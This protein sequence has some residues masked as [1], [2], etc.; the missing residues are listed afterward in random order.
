MTDLNV[1]LD[2]GE[3][4]AVTVR[5]VDQ[6]GYLTWARPTLGVEAIGDDYIAFSTYGATRA[7]IRTGVLDRTDDTTMLDLITRITEVET[8]TETEDPTPP[9]A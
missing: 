4:H 6:F 9:A 2:N 3:K 1:T 7:L 8:I 5:P